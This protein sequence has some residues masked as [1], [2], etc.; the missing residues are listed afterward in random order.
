[1]KQIK[2]AVVSISM[3]RINL[4]NLITTIAM[5]VVVMTLHA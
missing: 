1:M 5:L 2:K 4:Y 3:I